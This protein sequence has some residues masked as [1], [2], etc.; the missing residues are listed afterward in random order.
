MTKLLILLLPLISAH[1]AGDPLDAAL[2][3]YRAVASYS[4]TIHSRN[5][6]TVEKLRYFYKRPGFIRM[7]F[8]RPH[9][10]A[11]L[12]YNP[13]SHEAKLRPLGLLKPFV[14][15]LSPDN[16]LITSSRGH[17]VDASDIGGLLETAR[18][19]RD[20]GKITSMETADERG[21]RLVMLAVEGKAGVVVAGTVHRCI[22][23][24]DAATLLPVRTIT[25]EENGTMVEDVTLDGLEVNIF[26]PDELFV[27]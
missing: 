8:I 2:A 22:L 18:Q 13:L 11:V 20:K 27:L 7:E 3:R 17:R 26:L 14:L 23:W 4:V 21:R 12:V 25:Y 6:D 9:E 19:L 15:T 24:L 16:P 5:D 1:S 10:G